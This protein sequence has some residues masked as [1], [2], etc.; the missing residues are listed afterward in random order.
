M[1]STKKIN[2]KVGII[3]VFALKLS[4]GHYILIMKCR[5]STWTN[6]D[7]LED[8]QTTIA[9]RAPK[10]HTRLHQGPKVPLNS[11]KLHQILQT[12]GYQFPEYTLYFHWDTWIIPLGNQWKCKNLFQ[13][14][15]KRKLFQDLPQI[16]CFFPWVMSHPSTSFNGNL[17]ISGT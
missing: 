5:S 3:L 9:L 15:K 14:W 10:A 6:L 11:I 1:E 4:I 12:D 8:L 7:F 2:L 17:I 16:Y 13:F